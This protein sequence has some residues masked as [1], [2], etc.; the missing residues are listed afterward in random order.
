VRYA[1]HCPPD[2]WRG[3]VRCLWTLEGDGG[4]GAPPQ[5]V[6]PDGR[7]EVVVHLRD[8]FRRIAPDGH[9]VPARS[10]VVAG[11]LTRAMH[12]EPTGSVHC[13]GLRL[14]PAGARALLRVPLGELRDRIVPLADVLGDDGR[15]LAEALGDARGSDEVVAAAWRWVAARFRG[16]PRASAC[17]AAIAR[18]RADGGAAPVADVAS[19]VGLSRRQVER[20]FLAEVGVPPKRFARIVRLQRAAQRLR[21][22][23]E[24]SLARLALEVGCAD[25]AH[26]SREFVEIAGIPPSRWAQEEHAIA[27]AFLGE[28]EAPAGA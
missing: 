11:Q 17:D 4:A 12:L 23:P 2:A 27:A 20:R 22:D 3:L 14:E 13:V 15:R 25:Q 8:P 5:R 6:L 7:L 1:E 26:L 18:W 10:A 16:R 28:S 21:A 9:A 24:A 19:S